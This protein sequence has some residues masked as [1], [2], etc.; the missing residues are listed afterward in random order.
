MEQLA[1]EAEKTV[2]LVVVVAVWLMYHQQLDKA[3]LVD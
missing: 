2:V 1:V 3:V